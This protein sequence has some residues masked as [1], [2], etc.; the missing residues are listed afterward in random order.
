MA[1]IAASKVTD[2]IASKS[3]VERWRENII[4]LEDLLEL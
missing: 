2:R 1:A 4:T 3:E